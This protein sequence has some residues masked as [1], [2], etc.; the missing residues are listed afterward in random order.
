MKQSKLFLLAMLAAMTTAFTACDDSNKALKER[1]GQLC[2]YI[3]DHQLRED[4]AD[5]MTED[6]YSVLSEAFAS[7]SI[8][9]Y[10]KDWLYYF[11]SGNDGSEPAFTVLSVS[12]T[13]SNHAVARIQVELIG[14]DG[15]KADV[16]PTVY[17]M[18]L[19]RV[20]GKWLMSDFNRKKQQCTEFVEGCRKEQAVL[21]TIKQYL[22]D[23]IGSQ[24]LQ[25]ELCIPC[26]II[27]G[28]EE[29]ENGE[30]RFLGDYWVYNYNLQGDTLF[31][32]SGGSHPGCIR[33]KEDNG[34]VKVI[35]F[36]RVT[37]GAGFLP[38]AKRIFGLYFEEFQHVQSSEE[39]RDE[40]RK[41]SIL[42]YA[43]RHD[44][45]VNYVKDYGWDAVALKK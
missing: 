2:Q 1:A 30:V 41:Q 23:S 4:A 15:S 19:E 11:V 38:S 20:D 10:D 8:V 7:E 22:A 32:V 34:A 28:A 3:P 13:D 31:M 39:V 35:G 40:F 29:G 43:K 25:A 17:D 12:K 5:F 45:K 42:D 9:L 21:D 16:E 27:I 33:L 36:D 6:F 37:D 26:P 14:E 18:E 44:L 24:Y